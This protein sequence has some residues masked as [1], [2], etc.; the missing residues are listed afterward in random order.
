MC[1]NQILLETKNLCGIKN[2]NDILKYCKLEW[3][4][5]LSRI[6]GSII[7]KKCENI[8]IQGKYPYKAFKGGNGNLVPMPYVPNKIMIFYIFKKVIMSYSII[9]MKNVYFMTCYFHEH[10]QQKSFLH[11][12]ILHLNEIQN[13]NTGYVQVV[14]RVVRFKEQTFTKQ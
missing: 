3:K 4:D 14:N 12:D 5:Y 1:K 11:Y 9:L 7:T 13:K 10:K 2:I 8:S 6:S